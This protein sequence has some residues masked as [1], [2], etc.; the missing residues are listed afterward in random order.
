MNL[1]LPEEINWGSSFT[2]GDS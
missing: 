2:Y 1:Q